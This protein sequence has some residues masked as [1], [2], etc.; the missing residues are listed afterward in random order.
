M[1]DSTEIDD[2]PRG[3]REPPMPGRQRLWLLG[4]LVLVG[5]IVTYWAQHPPGTLFQA[6]TD[7]VDDVGG[8]DEKSRLG[9]S[10]LRQAREVMPAGASYT[11]L[12]GDAWMEMSLYMMSRGVLAECV[13]FPTS[14]FGKPAANAGAGARFVLVYRC[15]LR[16]PGATLVRR[17]DD[18][19]IWDRGRR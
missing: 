5:M 9:W 7:P 10:F 19:C 2:A 15:A 8:L 14:Y 6:G 12:A 16:P 1:E 11:I 3:H 4:C 18:G 17:L 13:A